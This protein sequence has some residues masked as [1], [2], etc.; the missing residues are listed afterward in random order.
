MEGG[1]ALDVL[2]T[3]LFVADAEHLH[4]ERLGVAEGRAPGAPGAR[5]RAVGELDQVERVLDVGRELVERHELAAVELAGHAAVEDRQR[6]GADVLGELEVLEE[7]QAER[8]VVV[9]R[10]P[11][12]ELVV[13]AVDQELPLRDR[14]DRLLPL[15]ADGEPGP[16]DDAAAGEAQEA[17][18]EVGERLHHVR[19]QSAAAILPGLAREERNHV[20][21]D[22]ARPVQDHVQ[23]ALRIG[24]VRHERQLDVLP[25]GGAPLEPA[26]RQRRAVSA[27]QLDRHPGRAGRDPQVG[28]E[29][30]GVSPW[31]RPMPRKPSFD[32]PNGAVPSLR[33]RR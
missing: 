19:P 20:E 12:L 8:L 18:V 5:H 6:L 21:V 27:H 4:V 16:L 30:I 13:P 11:M 33:R 31:R 23:P 14:A 3:P 7:A 26:A 2:R 10:R 22:R 28:R 24:V 25:L 29:V 32:T 15:V 9:R 17:R 1:V